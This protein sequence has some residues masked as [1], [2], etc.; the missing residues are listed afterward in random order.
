MRNYPKAPARSSPKQS[1]VSHR[2]LTVPEHPLP[3]SPAGAALGGAR[4]ALGP[5]PFPRL[6]GGPSGRW[7]VSAWN[8]AWEPSRCSVLRTH[9]PLPGILVT[10]VSCPEAVFVPL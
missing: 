8:G 7:W 6:G 9:C 10:Q 3:G 5:K 1:E 4:G 2:L